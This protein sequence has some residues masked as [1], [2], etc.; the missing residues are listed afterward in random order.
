[1]IYMP[2]AP[3]W[4]D[5]SAYV[6]ATLGCQHLLFLIKSDTILEH[7]VFI[8]SLA[9]VCFIIPPLLPSAC[10]LS[11]LAFFLRAVDPAASLALCTVNILVIPL[12]ELLGELFEFLGFSTLRARLHA[13]LP[14]SLTTTS[15]LDVF[16]GL[17]LSRHY[18][19]H[20]GS[21]PT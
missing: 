7:I 8:H 14:Y 17:A 3:A 10:A 15:E 1:M 18:D 19:A 13:G 6:A 11:F 5:G 21:C 16:R 20:L 9:A 4:D 12:L 2:T